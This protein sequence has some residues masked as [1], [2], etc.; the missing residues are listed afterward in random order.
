MLNNNYE[1]ILP[2]G[3][4]RLNFKEISIQLRNANSRTT[5]RFK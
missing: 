5:I 1:N 3:M 2:F 4:S